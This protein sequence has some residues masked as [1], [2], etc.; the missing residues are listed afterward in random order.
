M[1]NPIPPQSA[2]LRGAVD[3]SGL[4]NRPAPQAGGDE[5]VQTVPSF[6]VAADETSFQGV[7]ELSRTVP[8]VVGLWSARSQASADFLGVLERLVRE[9]DG[10]MLLA[11]VETD[12]NPQL[13][14]AFQVQSV[15]TAVA[16]VGGQPVQLFSGAQPEDVIGQVFDQ[17]LQLAAQNGV[18]GRV[19]VDGEAEPA[20]EAAEPVEEPLPPRHQ[21]AYDAIERG[22]YA[23]AIEEYRRA[24]A[25]N[26]ADHLATAGLAQVGLLHR[27]AGKS[28]EAIRSAAASAPGDLDAQLDVADLD[29][30]GGHVEDAFDRLLE[31][32]ASLPQADKDRVRAR[33][34]DYFEVVGSEDPRVVTARRRLTNLLY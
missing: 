20:A 9:R 15:P 21:A 14:Q 19:R 6:V 26:P 22:D 1:T 12:Q 4:V 18:S 29:L 17:L 8:V 2:S 7:L 13:V 28:A 3:L 10:R 27:L 16:V 11:T 33:L 5:A 34:L 24:L 31:R 25:E 30:S 23:T 32:F